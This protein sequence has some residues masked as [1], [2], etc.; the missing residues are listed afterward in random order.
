[1][2]TLGDRM[3]MYEVLA[4]TKVMPR[5]PVLIRLDGKAFHTFTQ[6]MERPWDD[7]FMRAMQD[8]ALYLCER[9]A[10]CRLAYIQSDE[11]SLLLTDW[12]TFNTDAWFKYQVQKIASVAASVCTGGF[13]RGCC[14]DSELAR[15][16]VDELPAFDARVFNLPRHEVTNYFIW[17]QQDATRN[18]IQMLG[19]AHFTHE[20][21]HGV[22]ASQIQE[23]LHSKHGINWNDTSVPKKRG[24]CA[25]RVEREVNGKVK[26]RWEADLDIP[27][28]SRDRDYIE[29]YLTE[30]FWKEDT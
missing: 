27:I 16:I 11:I 14:R 22:S 17:R 13:I 10:G 12:D 24:V 5:V 30:P 18:S 8:A 20:E 6:D 28:F 29:K 25:S 15:L 19:Q 1:M 4:R 3:K 21:M 9:V 23:M 2:D 7:R 26:L